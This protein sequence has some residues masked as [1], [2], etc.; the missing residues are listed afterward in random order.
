[1]ARG[2]ENR[3]LKVIEIVGDKVR[4]VGDAALKLRARFRLPSNGFA[5]LL[6]GKDGATKLRATRPI[7]ASELRK[8]IDAMPMRRRGGR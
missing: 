8:T 4:G 3:D 6:I 7:S 5:A 1:M 2:V